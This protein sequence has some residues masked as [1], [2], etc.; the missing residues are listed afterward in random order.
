M[1]RSNPKPT[2]PE[3]G[4]LESH[5]T[6]ADAAQADVAGPEAAQADVAGPEAAQADVAG[7]QADEPQT[8]EPAGLEQRVAV[9]GICEDR[10]RVLLVRAARYLTVAGRWFLPGGGIDHGEDPVTALRRE[11]NEETGLDVEV[12]ELRGVLSDVFTLPSGN[13]LHTVRIVYAIDSYS[14]ALR[15]ETDGSSDAAR[16]VRLDEIGELPLAPYVQRAISELR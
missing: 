11:F 1:E 7:F 16:W 12:G 6:E 8:V 13:S 3:Q 15:D 5:A 10:D 2:G 4:A 9:Y 14:G